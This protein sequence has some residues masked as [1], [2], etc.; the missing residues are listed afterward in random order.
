MNIL[1]VQ[2]KRIG[3]LILTTSA[4]AAVREKLPRADITL[5]ISSDARELLPAIRGIDRTFIARKKIADARNWLTVAR[6]NYDYCFDFT[7]SD[8]SAFLTLLSAAKKRVV[9]DHPRFRKQLRSKTYNVLVDNPIGVMHTIDYHLALLQPLGISDASTELQLHLPP[10]AITEADGALATAQVHG[11]FIVLHPGSAR[12]EKFWEPQ[13]WAELVRFAAARELTCVITGS[14]SPVEQAQIAE[15]AKRTRERFIDLSGRVG[16]LGLAAIIRRARLL[17]SV[18]SAPVHLAAAMRTPQV[19]L[20]GPTNPYHWRPRA[21]PAVVLH[22]GQAAPT[23]NFSPKAPAAAVKLISTEQVID[24]ME[25]LLATP[26]GAI[27]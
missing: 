7:R 26:R 18:D 10:E 16:L 15:I 9:A 3:D 6:R 2:L 17:V 19:A 12:A 4:I 24:A 27:V 25:A 20:F 1:L 5:I 21:T 11:E 23:L 13:R 8:R 22:A 14:H